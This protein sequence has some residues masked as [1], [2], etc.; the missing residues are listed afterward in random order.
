MCQHYFLI[1][2]GLAPPRFPSSSACFAPKALFHFS[3]GR[4]PRNPI[5]YKAS[6]E[7]AIQPSIPD[8]ALV[9]INSVLAQQLAVFILKS[10][11]AMVVLLRIYVLQHALELT[12]AH[13]K[14]SLPALPEKTA[15]TSIKGFDP[16]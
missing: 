5:A 15:I 13:R 16:F 11:S 8:V 9:K 3:L 4:R 7:S 14:R 2:G 10:A 6:A 1:F 12:W